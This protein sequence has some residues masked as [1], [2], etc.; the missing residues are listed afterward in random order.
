MRDVLAGA[1]LTEVINYAFVARRRPVGAPG[2]CPGEPAGRGPGGAPRPRWSCPGLLGTLRTNLR[3][4]RR[5][6]RVFELGR[7]FREGDGPCPPRTAGWPSCSPA[8]LPAHWSGKPRAVDFFDLKGT[9]RAARRAPVAG[10]A[11]AFD[12]GGRARRP[13]PR[14][15]GHGP[16]GDGALGYLGALHPDL[17]PG[18]GAPRGRGLRRGAGA[19]RAS[20]RATP[21]AWGRSRASP[22][23]S[24]DLSVICERRRRRAG[25]GGDRPRGGRAPA[26]PG[27]RSPTAMI[28]P[29]AARE[30]ERDPGPG[31]PG[32]RTDPDRRGS[33]GGGGAAG[34]GARGPAASRSAES[35][36]RTTMDDAFKLLEEKV[37][38]AAELVRRLREE[39]RGLS[40]ELGRVRPRLQ[41]LEKAIQSLEKQRGASADED[42][43]ARGPG[44]RG[45]AA[46]GRSGRR[47]ASGSRA[48]SRCWTASTA[49][50]VA[51]AIIRARRRPP[52][53]TDKP[54]HVQV[55]IFGQSYTVRAGA[56]PGYVEALAAHV[57]AQMREV[58]QDRGRRGFGARG[59]P[60]RPQHRRRVFPPALRPQGQRRQVPRP[61]RRSWPGPSPPPLGND[62]ESAD[63]R[64]YHHESPALLVMVSEA[65]NQRP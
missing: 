36:G 22:R 13:A 8:P 58:S 18:L 2:A 44:Q 6:V 39:N 16:A 37:K 24:R 12:R 31:L 1:G 40:E 50:R 19:V 11:F 46:C 41:E 60:G 53:M 29:R 56:D 48:W 20:G 4:G 55:E 45:A 17:A 5:D 35:E 25:A 38:K 9:R 30:G 21:C 28:G 61:G 64:G 26:A 65:L 34:A 43:Q 63:R 10:P 52:E 42:A 49:R 32:P 7:V 57:D 27:P 15:G 54:N 51:G 59:R 3:Q 33:A 14:A 47:S 62:V 23:S